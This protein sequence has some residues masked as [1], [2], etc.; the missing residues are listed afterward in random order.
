MNGLEVFKKGYIARLTVPTDSIGA[1][2]RQ[3]LEHSARHRRDGGRLDAGCASVE[4]STNLLGANHNYASTQRK[5]SWEQVL[6]NAWDLQ[7]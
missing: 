4:A 7:R 6:P 1:T 3:V 2:R 5:R